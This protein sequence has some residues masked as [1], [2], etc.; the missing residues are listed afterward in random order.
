MVPPWPILYFLEGEGLVT[1]KIG[2]TEPKASEYVVV[3]MGNLVESGF[4]IITEFAELD[5]MESKLCLSLVFWRYAR[6]SCI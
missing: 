5:E 2:E 3:G 4:E 1:V 6:S